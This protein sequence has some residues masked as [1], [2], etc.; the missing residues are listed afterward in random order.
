MKTRS[1]FETGP[2]WHCFLHTYSRL[3]LR[4]KMP[5]GGV[6]SS[7]TAD[8]LGPW[9]LQPHTA[10]LNTTRIQDTAGERQVFPRRERPKKLLLG[11]DSHPKMLYTS[12]CPKAAIGPLDPLCYTHAQPVKPVT[13]TNNVM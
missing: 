6:A 8:I 10:S 2:R 9:A 12:M 1:C 13:L 5:V 3:L 7:L 4:H 11:V